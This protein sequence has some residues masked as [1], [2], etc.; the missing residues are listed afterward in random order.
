MV[1]IYRIMIKKKITNCT[2]LNLGIGEFVFVK[3]VLAL[4]LEVSSHF[5]TVGHTLIIICH[6]L[7]FLWPCKSLPRVLMS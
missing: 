3:L 5:I 4:I 7:N 2:T 6:M 1:M